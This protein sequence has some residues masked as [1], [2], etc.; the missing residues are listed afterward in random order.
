[1]I[2]YLRS[3]S[4]TTPNSRAAGSGKVPPYYA[5]MGADSRRRKGYI[6]I[7]SS[8]ARPAAFRSFILLLALSLLTTTL[9]SILPAR[10]VAKASPSAVLTRGAVGRS[11][12]IARR[13]A[14]AWWL[15][16]GTTWSLKGPSQEGSTR[17]ILNID[18]AFHKT[19][20]AIRRCIA[21]KFGGGLVPVPAICGIV[22][23]K[24][25]E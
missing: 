16:F 3:I 18:S 8:V 23:S 19:V 5:A 10:D 12:L 15:T 6:Q 11:S 4:R 21:I 1:M 7:L 22:E 17:L 24:G 2:D 20:T 9:F 14:R 25:Y 13:G